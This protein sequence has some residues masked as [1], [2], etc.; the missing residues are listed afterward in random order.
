MLEVHGGDGAGAFRRGG[1][2]GVVGDAIDEPGQSASALEQRL[3]GGR[4]E[5]GQLAAG[6]AQAVGEVV[7]EF[8][9]VDAGEVVAYDEAL[10]RAIRARPWRGGG[11]AR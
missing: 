11:A 7:V 8:R 10:G 9:A 5:Q 2:E 6:E 4:L 3:D 1:G